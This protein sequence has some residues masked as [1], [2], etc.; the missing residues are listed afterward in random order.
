MA[1]NEIKRIRIF[2]QESDQII[3]CFIKFSFLRLI[4]AA[5]NIF[6]TCMWIIAVEMYSSPFWMV[7]FRVFFFF[8]RKESE[9]RLIIDKYKDCW[10]G[11]KC[12]FNLKVQ[13][14]SRENGRKN[15]NTYNQNGEKIISIIIFLFH[16]TSYAIFNCAI[17][18]KK[19]NV[20]SRS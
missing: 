20:N 18:I 8:F 3:F 11:P 7:T 2:L 10:E 12:I 4:L 14:K 6:K 13:L 15:W 5:S 19:L 9:F 17:Y 1:L 16:L